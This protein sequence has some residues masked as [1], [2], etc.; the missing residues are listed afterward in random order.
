MNKQNNFILIDTE[1]IKGWYQCEGHSEKQYLD[2]ERY[3]IEKRNVL[4][5]H[6]LSIVVDFDTREITGD[7]IAYGDWFDLDLYEACDCLLRILSNDEMKTDYKDILV[8]NIWQLLEDVTFD[9][10]EN[11]ELV[12]ADKFFGFEKGTTR[13]EIWSWIDS[14]YSKGVSHLIN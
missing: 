12:L 11:K 1:K 10:D 5:T 3:N 9:E 8:E 2:F 4:S 13:T 7:C 6:E 14:L